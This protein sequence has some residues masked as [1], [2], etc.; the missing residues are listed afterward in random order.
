MRKKVLVVDDSKLLHRFYD[1]ALRAYPRFEVEALFA[2]DGE[3]GLRRLH[4]HPDVDLVFLDVNMPTMSGLEFLRRMKSQAA[5]QSLRVVVQSAEDSGA[6]VMRG[7]EAGA[8]AYLTKPF[9]PPE[10]HAMLDQML[11]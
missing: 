11:S 3:E 7:L 5:L 8:A 1:A 10:L 6:D 9:T 2:E 4:E